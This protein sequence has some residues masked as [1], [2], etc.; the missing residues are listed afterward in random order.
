MNSAI[1]FEV[2]AKDETRK[3]GVFQNLE[4]KCS[5]ILPQTFR[6]R[7]R[8]VFW[9]KAGGLAPFATSLG[10]TILELRVPRMKEPRRYLRQDFLW[11]LP[12]EGV[13]R[14]LDWKGWFE[15]RVGCVPWTWFASAR[16][17]SEPEVCA[18]W[19]ALPYPCP[20]LRTRGPACSRRA[21]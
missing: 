10:A 11:I 8:R 2:K 7:K 1:D 3:E 21:R 19:R 16:C 13:L 17:Q 14:W 9:Q 18:A 15:P 5:S 20:P 4:Y 12:E 6:G